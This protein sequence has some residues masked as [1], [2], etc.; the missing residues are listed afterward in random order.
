MPPQKSVNLV[1]QV[2]EKGGIWIPSEAIQYK[3]DQQVV[4]VLAGFDAAS[5]HVLE[6]PIVVGDAKESA[7]EVKSGIYPGEKIV[8]KGASLLQHNQ[9]VDVIGQEALEL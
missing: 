6:R 4:Y 3:D 5:A 8:L 1:F 2:R 7:V 9:K